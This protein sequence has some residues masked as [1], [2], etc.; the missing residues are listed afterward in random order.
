MARIM[1]AKKNWGS[2]RGDGKVKHD[3]SGS[4]VI[5]ETL[6]NMRT[7]AALALE[8]QRL[9]QF[10]NELKQSEI[11]RIPMMIRRS[12]MEGYQV[13]ITRCVLD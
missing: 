11:D 8:E 2:D 4:N 7:V 9:E 12:L 1:Y 10:R 6:T 13:L 3:E 5:F